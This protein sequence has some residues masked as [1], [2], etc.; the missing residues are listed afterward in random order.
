MKYLRWMLL[1]V[2]LFLA[3]C[4]SEQRAGKQICD[5]T[6]SLRKDCVFKQA[7]PLPM[8][9][10]SQKSPGE[11]TKLNRAYATAPPLIPHSIEGVEVN[12]S[13]NGCLL[14][15]SGEMP[16]VPAIP[17]SHRQIAVIGISQAQKPL[18]TQV[19]GFKAA[20]SGVDQGRYVCLTCHVPQAGNLKPLVA[21]QF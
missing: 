20:P 5:Q 8:A 3:A 12:A 13:M 19:K 14:C 1:A 10:Y 9:L 16:D 6:L 11:S 7:Q 21:N 15:H 2:L 4:E 17:A 18:V